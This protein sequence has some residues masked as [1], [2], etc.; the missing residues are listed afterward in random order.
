MVQIQSVASVASFAG[1][2]NFQ[3]V[4]TAAFEMQPTYVSNQLSA[5]FA[6]AAGIWTASVYGASWV[7]E[8]KS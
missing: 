3:R 4:D 1:S 7:W 2:H 5:G 6:G 8:Y